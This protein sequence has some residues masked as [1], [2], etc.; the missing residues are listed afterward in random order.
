M[1]KNLSVMQAKKANTKA[2]A[3]ASTSD[4]QEQVRSLVESTMP[5]KTADELLIRT[6]CPQ[7]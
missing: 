4:N 6:S 3:G 5:R 1:I 2:L 7:T